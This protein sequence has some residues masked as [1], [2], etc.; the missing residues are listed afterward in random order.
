[1]KRRSNP[2]MSQKLLHRE[3]PNECPQRSFRMK[4][5]GTADAD[6]QAAWQRVGRVLKKS[7]SLQHQPGS[8]NRIGNLCH[9]TLIFPKELFLVLMSLS[10]LASLMMPTRYL[11]TRLY[12]FSQND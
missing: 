7:Q 6:L 5:I 1:M 8:P 4:N 12:Y 3:L 11:S 10:A 9:V 2:Q